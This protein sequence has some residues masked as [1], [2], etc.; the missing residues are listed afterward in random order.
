MALPYYGL[1]LYS[2]YK[3]KKENSNSDKTQNLPEYE[4]VIPAR[5][6][7]RHIQ[8]AIFSLIN[9][10][11]PPKRIHIVDDASNDGTLDIILSTLSTL[12]G[13]TCNDVKEERLKNQ[14]FVVQKCHNSSLN[15]EF[16]VWINKGEP[17]GKGASINELV[18]KYISSEYFLS[19]DADTVVEPDFAS[20]ILHH[21]SK[22][23]RVAASY[24]YILTRREEDTVIGRLFEWGRDI[25]NRLGYVIFR[26]PSNIIGFHY[27]LS[28]PR[29]V[30]KTEAYRKIP[31]PLDTEAGD[32]AHA[33]ELQAE[34]YEIYC[35]LKTFGVTWEPS[36]IKGFWRQ[37]LKWHSGPFQNLY[38]RGGSVLKRLRR[39]SMKKFLAGLYTILYYA[40]F[41]SLYWV[42]WGI[43]LPLLGIAGLIHLNFLVKYYIIDFLVFY[44]TTIYATYTLKSYGYYIDENFLT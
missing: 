37:R 3:T 24:G 32:T 14:K 10:T 13:T 31:R 40:I 25:A 8:K 21:M 16:W 1:S 36:T 27:G 42:K 23:N 18:S 4:A 44:V 28:G 12:R 11:H 15:I 6:E 43:L 20:K 19:L 38:I 35:D 33:W 7:K 2:I 39:R 5:N 22:N 17:L 30:F 29:V 41:S 26:F 9:Q 34:G